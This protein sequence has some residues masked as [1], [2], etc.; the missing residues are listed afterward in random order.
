MES[1]TG[2]K[3]AQ[4][5]PLTPKKNGKSEKSLLVLVI[6]RTSHKHSQQGKIKLGPYFCPSIICLSFCSGQISLRDRTVSVDIQ[7]IHAHTNVLGDDCV[8]KPPNVALGSPKYSLISDA[9]SGFHV[10]SI[11]FLKGGV[12]MSSKKSLQVCSS[13]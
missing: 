8:Y 13:L 11:K 3:N 9:L 10:L 5:F 12:N 1:T 6:T 4:F 2:T 7:F